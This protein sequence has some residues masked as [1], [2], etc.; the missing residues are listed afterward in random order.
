MKK[1]IF[2]FYTLVLICTSCTFSYDREYLEDIMA[3]Y[4]TTD[5]ITKK[6]RPTLTVLL[7]KTFEIKTRKKYWNYMEI[8]FG[9]TFSM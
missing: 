1:D 5:T 7:S 6:Q 2:F 8:L 3:K 9:T 4:N